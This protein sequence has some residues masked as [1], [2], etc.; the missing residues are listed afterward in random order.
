MQQT[1]RVAAGWESDGCVCW[2]WGSGFI[3]AMYQALGEANADSTDQSECSRIWKSANGENWL[4]LLSICHISL[5]RN[6]Q[7][8]KFWQTTGGY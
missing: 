3:E 1:M 2:G 5:S 8:S 7:F 6:L 4:Q